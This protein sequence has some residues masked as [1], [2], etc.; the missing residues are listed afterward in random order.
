M[1]NVMYADAMK[2]I[3]TLEVAMP[4]GSTLLNIVLALVM[5]GVA[6][7]IKPRTFLDILKNP[8]SMLIGIAC[9]VVLLPALTLCLAMLLGD[10]IPPMIALGMILVASCPGGKICG[11]DL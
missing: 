9:Q 11:P 8:K 1:I 2:A 5:F 6:L 4:G 3:D 10:Y 7:G